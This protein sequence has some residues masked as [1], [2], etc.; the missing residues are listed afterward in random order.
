MLNGKKLLIFD[1]D[2]VL[3]DSHNA[4]RAY[5]DHCLSM[6]GY[7]SLEGKQ[8]ELVA[9]MS[10]K[11]LIYTIF[12]DNEDEAKR[13]YDISKSVVYDPF[14]DSIDLKFN[15]RD[16]LVPLRSKFFLA[17]AS[18]RAKSLV[19]LFRHFGLFDYFHYKVPKNACFSLFP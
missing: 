2:G 3:I 15:F 8:R 18:N 7:P 9:Y 1:C 11:Q 4:N 14:L 19:T 10:I 6:A 12:E 17:V 16:V 5:F 13:V